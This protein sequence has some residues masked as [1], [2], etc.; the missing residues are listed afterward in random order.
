VPQP[1]RKE[2][3]RELN[4]EDRAVIDFERTWW[5][6]PANRTKQEAIRTCL[7]LSPTRYYA[8]LESLAERDEALAYDPL[9][10]RRLRRR[11]D[12]KR[13]AMFAAGDH[14]GQ[15]RR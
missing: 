9:L 2:P 3:S 12:R 15:R 10:I 5:T 1:S 6:V 7:G 11:R 13:R 4:D 8:A 14:G